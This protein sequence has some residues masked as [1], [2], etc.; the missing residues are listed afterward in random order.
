MNFA[1]PSDMDNLRVGN[2]IAYGQIQSF[3]ASR[4]RV[5]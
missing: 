3:A 5:A 4:E 1:G 2:P